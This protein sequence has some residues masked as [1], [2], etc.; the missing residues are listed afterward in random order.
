MWSGLPPLS[1]RLR[2]PRKDCWFRS[3]SAAGSISTTSPPCTARTATRSWPSWASSCSSTPKIGAWEPRDACLSGNVR[4]KLTAAREAGIERNIKALE[5]IQPEDILPGDIDANLGAPW[6]PVDVISD[7]AAG[8]FGAGRHAVQIDHLP[9]DAL[10]TVAGDRDAEGAVTNTE[11]FGTRRITGL[12]LLDQALNLRTPK[13]YD[14]YRDADG[15][16]K[17]AVNQEETVAALDKQKR[18]R[19]RF[20]GWIFSDPDRAERLVRIYND[21]FNN[22]VARTFDGSHQTLPGMT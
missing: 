1:R 18:I 2:R 22:L 7:F 8:L 14:E 16:T 15:N 11:E 6:I 10:W 13:I 3:M 17:R 20:S 4:R 9:K 21:T 19:E 12:A 5:A